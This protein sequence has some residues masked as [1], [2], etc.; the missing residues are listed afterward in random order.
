MAVLLFFLLPVATRGFIKVSPCPDNKVPFGRELLWHQFSA[1]IYLVEKFLE[2][3]T[4][5]LGASQVQVGFLWF[6][7]ALK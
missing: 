6:Y 5:A 4:A 2:P 3:S 1:L 7:E